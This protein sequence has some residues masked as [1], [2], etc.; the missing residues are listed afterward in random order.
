HAAKSIIV[1][2]PEN[3]DPDTEF[4]KTV[5]AI[6]NNPNRRAEPYHIVTQIRDARNMD[7]LKLVGEKDNVQAVLTGDLIARAVAQTSR[8][9]G[10]SVVY[11]ELMNFGGD[12]IYFKHEP[13][14]A[15]KTFGEALLA[16]EDSCLM[17]LRKADG[18]ILLGP[19]M[20]S[21]IESDDQIFALSADDDTL[22]LSSLKPA[23]IDET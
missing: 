12:E 11:T 17:G 23:A 8:Q 9:S 1:L 19:A 22:R 4:I 5:L 16:Y 21:R 7:V 20:D 3:S 2:P 13:A 14:L 10:L 18:R 6:T 15:G